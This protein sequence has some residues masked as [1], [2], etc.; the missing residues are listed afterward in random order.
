MA[1]LSQCSRESTSPAAS[2]RGSAAFAALS[3]ISRQ[4]AGGAVWPEAAGRQRTPSA[5]SYGA[6]GGLGTTLEEA[7]EKGGVQSVAGPVDSLEKPRD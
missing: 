7:F 4:S 1:I 3:P 6:A 5:E 2:R